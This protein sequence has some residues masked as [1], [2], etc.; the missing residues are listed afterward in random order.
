[1]KN[2]Y[3]GLVSVFL[4]GQAFSQVDLTE[5]G[6]SLSPRASVK[7]V[8]QTTVRPQF[9]ATLW[10]SD[11]SNLSDW[12]IG[13][14]ATSGNANWVIV[15]S[16]SEWWSN[17]APLAS[18]SGG[19]AAMFDSD[20]QSSAANLIQNNAWIQAGPFD[21]GALPNVAVSFEQYFNK[22][23]GRTFVE[24]SIDGGASWVDYEVNVG[25]AN[26][27]ETTNPAFASADIS[28]QAAGQGAVLV[29]I[30]YLSNAV[31]DGGTDHTAGD[32]WDYG[33]IV[34]DFQI[35]T[36]P[37]DDIALTYGWNADVVNDWEYSMIPLAQVKPMVPGVVIQ[38]Q[39]ALQQ[40]L[41][42]TAEISLGGS[43]VN[44]TVETAYT[45]DPGVT[46]TIWFTTNYTPSA[47]GVYTVDFSIEAD[48]DN[49]DNEYTAAT[50][51]VTQHI[52]AHDYGNQG[53]YGWNSS[54]TNPT[55]VGYANAPHAW[56]N[57]YTPT[58]G[59]NVYG[60]NIFLG[61]STTPN[62]EFTLDVYEIDPNNQGDWVQDPL[63]FVASKY[64]VPSAAQIGSQYTLAFDNPVALTGGKSYIFSLANVNGCTAPELFYIAGSEV[65]SE[66]DD[67]SSLAFGSYNS[68]NPVNPNWYTGWGWAPYIRANFDQTV[69]VEAIADN[70]VS[71]Y[72]NPTSGVVNVT[73]AGGLNNTIAVIDVTG[74]TLLSKTVST[75]TTVDLSTFGTGIYLVKVSNDKGQIVERVVVR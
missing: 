16:P 59:A 65:A 74:K 39:G 34:D 47:L 32:A 24:V 4:A 51:E 71:V 29:R 21:C 69:S 35:G 54:S 14:S 61:A 62:M 73:N 27:D 75:E 25:M 20:G 8:K 42:V 28:A 63:G 68:N 22:W 11:F 5:R 44:T 7:P 2:L 26:N 13:N 43:V 60:V 53:T 64:W 18:T 37:D 10:S 9:K 48:A 1:M 46:D 41:D 40:T 50:M 70:G 67:Y 23:T 58:V 66:D 49:N 6:K 30:L 17:N 33:W 72:P 3:L 52:M 15:N 36:L 57:I 55:V 56:A 12:T 31:S 19:N 38:N 45:I